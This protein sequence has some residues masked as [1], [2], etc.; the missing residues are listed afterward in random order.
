M[1]EIISMLLNGTGIMFNPNKE[2][3]RRNKT[4]IAKNEIRLAKA[5]MKHTVIQRSVNRI[6]KIADEALGE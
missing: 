4:L 1:S 5:R 3:I 6:R 2:I